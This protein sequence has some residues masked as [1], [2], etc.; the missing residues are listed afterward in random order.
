MIRNLQIEADVRTGRFSWLSGFPE[1]SVA[2]LGRAMGDTGQFSDRVD[3]F[4]HLLW[5]RIVQHVSG[6]RD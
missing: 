5:D 3:R 1:I 4:G 6:I 2:R